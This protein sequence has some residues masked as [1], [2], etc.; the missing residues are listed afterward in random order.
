VNN[1]ALIPFGRK[2][3]HWEALVPLEKS[4]VAYA[5]FSVKDDDT[6]AVDNNSGKCSLVHSCGR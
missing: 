5:I 1:R 2:G 3:D 4:H 6:K